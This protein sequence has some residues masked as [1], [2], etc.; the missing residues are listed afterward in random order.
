MDEPE[1]HAPHHPH[2]GPPRWLEWVTSVSALVVSVTSI[3]IAVHHGDTME[4]LVTANSLPYLTAAMS[5]A[6]LQGDDRLSLDLTNSGVGPAHEQSLKVQVGDRY[7]TSVGDLVAAIVGPQEAAAA[8]AVLRAYKN[9]QRERFIAANATQLVFRIDK[10]EANARY[11]A[12][13]DASAAKSWHYEVCYCSVFE[14]CWV[15]RD[16]ARKRVKQCR[17]DEAHEFTP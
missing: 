10:T 4:K 5:D 1:V 17:R 14:E 7:V 13:L 8:N 6:T 3:I 11:W 9:T 15:V 2:G 12:L 16:E